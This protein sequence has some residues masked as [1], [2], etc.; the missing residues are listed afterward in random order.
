[1][2]YSKDRPMPPIDELPVNVNSVDASLHVF[3]T[4][5]K[6][7]HLNLPLDQMRLNS[8][9]DLLVCTSLES[10]DLGL[11]SLVEGKN[12]YTLEYRQA[13]ADSG[14]RL[15]EL[16]KQRFSHEQGYFSRVPDGS[17]RQKFIVETY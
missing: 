4:N 16:A 3:V 5:K 15:V 10:S 14:E 1:M 12:L 9:C 17:Y 6:N 11:F 2:L 13:S 8:M 7:I